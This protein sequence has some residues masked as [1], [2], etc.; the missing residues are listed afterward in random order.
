MARSL[1]FRV[2]IRGDSTQGNPKAWVLLLGEM[3]TVAGAV[4]G[5]NSRGVP[6]ITGNYHEGAKNFA[7]GVA[8]D[9]TI[10]SFGQAAA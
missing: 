9:R 8:Q 3:V 5:R 2:A 4:N 7:K 10:A 1:P 6:F